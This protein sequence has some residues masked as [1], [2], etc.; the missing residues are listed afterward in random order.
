MQRVCAQGVWQGLLTGAGCL[1]RALGPL[2]V[3]AVYA[4]RGPDATF[5]ATA[6]LTLAAL[7]ALRLVYARLRAPAPAL[8]PAAQPLQPLQPLG[9]GGA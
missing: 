8:V 9:G 1:A 5:G 2:F 6:A 3:A 7:L 4:R